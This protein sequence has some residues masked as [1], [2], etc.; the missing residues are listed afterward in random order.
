MSS[1]L[2]TWQQYPPHHHDCQ[3]FN[4]LCV[5]ECRSLSNLSLWRYHKHLLP[6]YPPNI[7]ATTLQILLNLPLW[8]Y[9]VQLLQVYQYHPN[10]HNSADLVQ[11]TADLLRVFHPNCTT[12]P[13]DLLPVYHPNFT[14]YPVD[15]L[16]QQISCFFAYVFWHWWRFCWPFGVGAGLS[17]EKSPTGC[18]GNQRDAKPWRPAQILR[19]THTQSNL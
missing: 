8:L 7:T 18:L 15:L 9:H 4:A 2:Q 11:N 6:V 14:T 1:N 5:V 17:C 13:A 12:H 3:T 19:M 16:Q 10:N